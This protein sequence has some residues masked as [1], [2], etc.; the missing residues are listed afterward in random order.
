MEYI[1]YALLF[2][3]T[4]GPL[5]GLS[6][7]RGNGAV[8][9][10]LATYCG[11]GLGR[12]GKVVFQSLRPAILCAVSEII[13]QVVAHGEPPLGDH[14]RYFV[15]WILAL[16]VVQSLLLRPGFLHRFSMA[17]LF[18]GLAVVPFL[19][20]RTEGFLSDRA[21]AQAAIAGGFSNPNGLGNWFGFCCLY[22]TVLGLETRRNPVRIGAWLGAVGCLYVVGLSVSR[23][24]L[25][26][27]A[28]AVLFALRRILKRGF[29]PLLLLFSLVWVLFL[30][31]IFDTAAESFLARAEEDTGRTEVWPLVIQRYLESPLVGVGASQMGTYVPGR[32][33]YMP[34]NSF[35]C[36]AL[37]SGSIPLVFFIVYWIRSFKLSFKLPGPLDYG[38]FRIPF[39]VYTLM[40]CMA[41][42][43]L[44]MNPWALLALCIPSAATGRVRSKTAR[45]T[46]THLAEQAI[47][48]R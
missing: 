48:R 7:G 2:Y 17:V 46:Q 1:Y 16:V 47:A 6:A 40:V 8:L 23:G 24:A 31:G 34:H 21:G 33:A 44:F 4:L 27:L 29:A 12:T 18:L 43:F 28:V 22:L 13:V 41:G 39:L 19:S 26:A 10:L 36:F 42:D 37:T 20:V 45:R 25:A 11:L 3:G 14:I 35:L 15:T 32:I 38:A 9:L 5:V 30:F